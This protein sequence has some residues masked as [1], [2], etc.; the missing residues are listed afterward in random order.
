MDCHCLQSLS[1]NLRQKIRNF[2]SYN[3]TNQKL[4]SFHQS[5]DVN[6]STSLI[7]KSNVCL[8]KENKSEMPGKSIK[9]KHS[10]RLSSK[11]FIH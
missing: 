1:S 9:K 8:L 10:P 6:N 5:L 3:R 2:L 11:I 7:I 4:N